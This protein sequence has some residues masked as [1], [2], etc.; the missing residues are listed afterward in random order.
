MFVEK[1]INSRRCNK[2][3]NT[4]HD[5]ARKTPAVFDGIFYIFL[6][7]IR[8]VLIALTTNS[9]VRICIYNTHFYSLVV[10]VFFLW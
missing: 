3:M 8:F 5:G 6:A 7:I 1:A 10:V 4:I 2:L 9:N